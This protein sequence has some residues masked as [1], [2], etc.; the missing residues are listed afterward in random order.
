MAENKDIK[1]PL[2]VKNFKKLLSDGAKPNSKVSHEAIVHWCYRFWWDHA[3]GKQ[4]EKADE[5]TKKAYKI[6][7]DVSVQWESFLMNNFTAEE[8][9]N[10]QHTDAKMPAEWFQDWLKLLK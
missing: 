3:E 7:D 8:R 10:A 6:A 5:L 9:E 1:L 4:R 2:T